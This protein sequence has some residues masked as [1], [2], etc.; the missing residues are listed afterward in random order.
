[1][2]HEDDQTVGPS[3]ST[4]KGINILVRVSIVMIEHHNQATWEGKG[5]V[6]LNF[7]VTVDHQRNQG[8]NLSKARTWQA[9]DDT[10]MLL[11]GLLSQ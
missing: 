3:K 10:G 4:P 9:G 5:L 8:S 1:M 6:L 11:T 2:H 7:H